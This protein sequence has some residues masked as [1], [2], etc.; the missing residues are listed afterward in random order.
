MTVA[1]TSLGIAYYWI[2]GNGFQFLQTYVN[3]QKTLKKMNEMK[4][5][6]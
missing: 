4:G 1:Y 5:A 6:A 2:I 3:R